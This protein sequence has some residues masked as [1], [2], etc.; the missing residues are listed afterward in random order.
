MIVPIETLMVVDPNKF[1]NNIKSWVPRQLQLF[2]QFDFQQSGE[3]N[4]HSRVEFYKGVSC[5]VVSAVPI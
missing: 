2:L 4:S 1:R 5:C 3:F